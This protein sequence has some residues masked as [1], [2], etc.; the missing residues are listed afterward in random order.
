MHT[1]LAS[2][3]QNVKCVRVLVLIHLSKPAVP[4]GRIRSDSIVLWWVGLGS[5]PSIPTGAHLLLEY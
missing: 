3:H 1:N 5:Q 4:K 2:F